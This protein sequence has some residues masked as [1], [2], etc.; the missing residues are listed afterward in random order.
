MS[1][2]YPP[3]KWIVLG[4][5]ITSS[6]EE[7][8]FVDLFLKVFY[9]N[10]NVFYIK[11]NLLSLVEWRAY[12]CYIW[13]QF[14]LLLIFLVTFNLFCSFKCRF[15]FEAF[16]CLFVCFVTAFVWFYYQVVI[17][18]LYVSTGPSSKR[19][20]TLALHWYIY[21]QNTHFMFTGGRNVS[22]KY[23]F[24]PLA[25]TYYIWVRI[26]VAQGKTWAYAIVLFGLGGSL[27][28]LKSLGC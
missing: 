21:S 19:R 4:L 6:L 1:G 28:F 3:S 24:P 22:S 20:M 18:T 13:K 8:Q 25:S 11:I 26:F 9:L 23:V 12:C 10:W 5:T 15:S 27:C 7:F 2:V 16:V 17:S 14:I